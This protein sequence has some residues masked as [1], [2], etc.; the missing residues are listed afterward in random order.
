MSY[1]KKLTSVH[2]MTSKEMYALSKE[3]YKRDLRISASKRCVSYDKRL[4]SV[5]QMMIS[6]WYRALQMVCVCV[7]TCVYMCVC[8]CVCVYA[9]VCVY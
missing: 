5:Y 9:C 4:T 6:S 2:Q 3:T 8:V 7:C 1:E